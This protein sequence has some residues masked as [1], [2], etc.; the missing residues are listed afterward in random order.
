MVK[1]QKSFIS[2]ICNM[3]SIS[4]TIPVMKHQQNHF[5][6]GC[7]HSM[8]NYIK[9]QSLRKVEDHYIFMSVCLSQELVISKAKSW[10][11]KMFLSVVMFSLHFIFS[12]V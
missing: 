1:Y 11:C 8:G 7:H 9:G 6:V 12:S 5:T 2:D 3:S 10:H 4:S